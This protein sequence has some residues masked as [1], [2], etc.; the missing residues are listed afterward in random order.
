MINSEVDRFSIVCSN[1][2]SDAASTGINQGMDV[3]IPRS[4]RLEQLELP[5]SSAILLFGVLPLL[6]CKTA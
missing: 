1:P 2:L 3:D 4:F 6:D 5:V